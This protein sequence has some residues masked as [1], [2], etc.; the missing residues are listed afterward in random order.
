[1]HILIITYHFT[2]EIAAYVHLIKDL[3]EDLLENDFKISILTTEATRNVK[4]ES[5]NSFLENDKLN[6][7]R[8]SSNFKKDGSLFLK[9]LG[10][11]EF[12]LKTLFLG[13]KQRNI[14]L[15]F[16]NTTP[17]TIGLVGSIISFLKNIP[18]V[19]NVQDIFPDSAVSTG[20]IKNK[21]I[22]RI[23]NIYEDIV[24]KSSDQI[25]TISKS[26]KN[27]LINKGI[28]KNKIEIVPNWIDEKKVKQISKSNNYIYDKYNI[29]RDKFIISYFGNIGYQQNFNII[30]E[31]AK[32]LQDNKDILFII[33]GEGAKKE[34]LMKR[35]AE[36]GLNNLKFLPFQPLSKVNYAYSFGDIGLVTVHKKVTENAMPSKTWNILS[37]SK[38]VLVIADKSSNLADIIN[39]N[40]CGK[41]VDNL[42]GFIEAILFYYKNPDII[43]EEGNNGRKYIEEN[44][45]RKVNTK[46]YIDIIKENL[47]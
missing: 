7:I 40:R 37:V 2:P 31:A 13:M 8:I 23:A 24:Y 39:E 35:K 11:I 5:K 14:D 27:N 47:N 20:V 9:L 44:L 12:T 26:L 25:I 45:S 33:G 21:F 18:F 6:I 30:L 4:E 38:P 28:N 46:K 16:T 15:V 42:D 41:V 36:N 3:T 43:Y 17:P 34:K 10:G 19:Y 29:S 22:I 32:K 1:M